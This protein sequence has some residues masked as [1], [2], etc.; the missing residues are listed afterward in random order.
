MTFNSL[1]FAAFFVVVLLINHRLGR[2]GQNRLMILAG[3]VFYGFFD[4]RFLGLL[5][6]S[7]LVDFWIGRA[8][9]TTEDAGRRRALFG[10]SLVIQLGIL[11]LF[12]YFN[13]FTDSVEKVLGGFGLDADFVTI[14]VLVPVGISFYTFQS[15]A[16]VR[17]VYKR[18][19]EAERDLVTFA[20]FVS[21][22]P[23]M[24]AGPIERVTSILPQIQ[25]RRERP[26]G[27]VIESG[28]V[29]ILQGL[30]K[31]VVLADGVAIYVTTV[32]A[33][34]EN[35][36]FIALI[37]ATA[38]FA[39]QVYGDFSGY[40][41]MARGVSRLLGVE[42]RRNFE[43][44][45]LSRDIREFWLRWHTS[46]SWWFLEFVGGPM[47]AK[48]QGRLWSA[49]VV[50]VMFSLIGLWHGAAWTFVLWGVFNGILVAIWRQVPTN[51]RRHPMRVK[52][53][54]MPAMTVT[55]AIFC[56]GAVMF[57]A[58]TVGDAFVVIE[59]IFTLQ[60]GA[61]GPK[62]ILLVPTMLLLLLGIDV[63]ERRQRVKAIEILRVRASLG[64]V[65]SP[66]EAVVESL[67]RS[68]GPVVFGAMAA[69]AVV[70][71]VVFSGGAPTP[72]VYF[73]F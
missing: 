54:D 72:F 6:L 25:R 49:F 66:P 50:V 27:P 17:A 73:Q 47:N 41:D 57:R 65:A 30:F 48:R 19:F 64:S 26:E 2:V 37:L 33:E 15:L 69:F 56:I 32:Y 53:R 11:G 20:A 63:L 58:A 39:V 59:R 51:Q 8:L 36:S 42:L 43:Q 71:I 4:V 21:W 18:Q 46:L 24:A 61:S 5:W 45:F 12:K 7:I 44:P 29:L 9:G 10:A 3:S 22:F 60:G 62:S 68:V 34:P 13:F 67:S 70:M 31:K 52:A 38:G 35:Y 55:F 40:T 16:Y 28:L 23:Q 1:T 14:N